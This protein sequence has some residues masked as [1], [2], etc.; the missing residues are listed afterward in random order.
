[1]NEII[2]LKILNVAYGGDG[3]ARK[4]NLVYF[5]PKTLP[6]EK[7][8]AEIVEKKK[9]YYKAKLIKILTPSQERTNPV[10]E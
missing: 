3:I 2:D 6:D 7:V 1:M 5:V 10:C 4:N 9:N 8:Q